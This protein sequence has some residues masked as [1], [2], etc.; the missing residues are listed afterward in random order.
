[1]GSF[2]SFVDSLLD[3]FEDSFDDPLDS[4]SLPESFSFFSLDDSLDESVKKRKQTLFVKNFLM[5]T[6]FQKE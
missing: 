1:M 5:L 6:Y 3:S 4:F 2:D